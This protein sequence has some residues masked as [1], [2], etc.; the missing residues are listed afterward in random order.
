MKIFPAIDLLDEKV[1]RLYQGDYQQKEV[2]GDDPVAFAQSFEKAGAKYLHLVDLDG[3]KAGKLH[4]FGIAK[5]IVEN[6]N[7]KRLG[8]SWYSGESNRWNHDHWCIWK[9][10]R[11]HVDESG[12]CGSILCRSDRH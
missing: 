3:A 10:E 7:L 11:K 5:K 1:V 9:D 2:F 12:Q 4:Y 6:T 8:Q